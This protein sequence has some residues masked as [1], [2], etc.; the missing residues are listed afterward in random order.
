MLLNCC[1]FWFDNEKSVCTFFSKRNIFC[2]TPFTCLSSFHNP[3]PGILIPA[4]SQSLSYN[5][6]SRNLWCNAII[7]QT[8]YKTLSIAPLAKLQILNPQHRTVNPKLHPLPL[9]GWVLLGFQPHLIA[10]SFTQYTSQ[11]IL[12]VW[13]V[14]KTLDLLR[15]IADI[16]GRRLNRAFS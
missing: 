9:H 7:D 14:L 12:Y 3:Q 2:Y 15:W 10:A 1:L 5:P 4:E 8:F 13:Q 16:T 6:K 11:T